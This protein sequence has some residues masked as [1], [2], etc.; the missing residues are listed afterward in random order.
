MVLAAMA[1]VF[2]SSVPLMVSLTMT[3]EFGN[4]VDAPKT[5]FR[6]V[7][8]VALVKSISTIFLDVCPYTYSG[9]RNEALVLDADGYLLDKQGQ[10]AIGP[11]VRDVTITVHCDVDATILLKKVG[12]ILEP[13]AK[14]RITDSK[15][16]F[17]TSHS[18]GSVAVMVTP[19]ASRS[20]MENN[21]S[22]SVDESSRIVDLVLHI[23]ES[24]TLL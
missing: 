5:G 14:V 15:I 7:A 9:D 4:V 11:S 3:K 20:G 13:V 16:E 22:N 10:L 21:S 24:P 2:A 8:T 18:V 19:A 12:S 17:Q 23:V 6:P 1:V